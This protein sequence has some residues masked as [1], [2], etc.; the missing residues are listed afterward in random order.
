[1]FS[2]INQAQSTTTTAT[3][4]VATATNAV[5]SVLENFIDNTRADTFTET[6]TS[7]AQL[8]NYNTYA[9]QIISQ[10]TQLKQNAYDICDTLILQLMAA[11]EY[12]VQGREMGKYRQ[13]L[14]FGQVKTFIPELTVNEQ[15]IM[16]KLIENIF[17]VNQDDLLDIFD[18]IFQRAKG[19]FSLF[20]SCQ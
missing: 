14:V 2:V 8:N 20:S 6:V 4:T 13:E 3:K 5:V 17:K 7:Q 15:I 11:A 16:L 1:M 12:A 9:Q 10:I 19:C 18:K